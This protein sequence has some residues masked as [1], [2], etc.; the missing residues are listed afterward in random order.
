M[1][2]NLA[3]NLQQSLRLGL[4]VATEIWS[5]PIGDWVSSVHAADIDGD[6]D[7]EILLA[8][9]NSNIYILAKDRTLEG[10]YRS[11]GGW[12]RTIRGGDNAGDSDKTHIVVGSRDNRVQ[13]LDKNGD[14][15]S[16]ILVASEDHCLHVL[17]SETG[18]VL[19]KYATGGVVHAV[20][21]DDIDLDGEIEILVTSG[22]AH[23]Y[24]L[25][26]QGRVKWKSARNAEVFSILAA[27]I[28]GDG[29]IEILLASNAEGIYALTAQLQEKWHFPLDKRVLSLTI[30]DLDRDG[31]LEIIAAAED[32]HLYF[33]DQKGQLL[34]SH[35][36][37]SQVFSVYAIDLDNDGLVEILVGTEDSIRVLRIELIRN[38]RESILATHMMLGRP[39]APKLPLSA[40]EITLLQEITNEGALDKQFLTLA[41]VKQYSQSG[42]YLEM[43]STLML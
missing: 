1:A 24:S 25:D 37:N 42:N 35:S 16:E 41:S 9:R 34:W 23:L 7:V 8:S 39:L 40:N 19:W 3:W 27:D 13:A 28:D 15:K 2:S 36:L 10:K 20:D 14:G 38:L 4:T 21:A 26:S 29:Q 43:L 18:E 11:S 31:Q 22:D 17:S 6:G 32:T 12:I 5:Y 30:A 33:L